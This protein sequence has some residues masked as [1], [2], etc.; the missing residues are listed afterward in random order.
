[1]ILIAD[2]GS[3]KTEWRGIYNGSS[4]T[5][6]TKGINP[7]HQTSEEIF[8]SLKDDFTIDQTTIKEIYFYGAGCANE[9]KINIVRKALRDFFNINNITV[10]SD[11]TGAARSLCGSKPGIACILGTG[12]NSCL[13]DG[14]NIKDNVSP[15]GYI[16][17]DE[18]SGA[19]MGKKLIGDILKNQL[20]E[21]VIRLFFREHNTNRAQILDNIYKK[22]LANRYLAQ[23]TKFLSKHIEIEEIYNLV[24]NAFDEFIKR[25]LLQYNN[26]LHLEINF[27]GSIAY[28]FQEQ[29]IKALNKN[30]LT[31][32]AVTQSPMDGLEQYHSKTK[33]CLVAKANKTKPSVTESSSKFDNLEIMSVEKL[34]TS[35]NH[36]DAYVH[37]AVAK[38][39]PQVKEL[40]ERIV[41]RMQKG[42]RVFYLGAG[43][44]GRL[45]V[46][47]ASELPPTF[48]VPD[49]MVIGL[50]AGGDAAL[51]KAVEAAEDDPDKAWKELLAFDIN[52]MDTVIGIAASG[53][54]PYVVGGIRQARY[55]GLLTGCITCNPNSKVAQVTEY[56]IEAIVGPEFVTGSTRLKAGTAQKMILNMMTTTIMIK[57]GRVKGNQMVNMQLTSEKLVDRGSR[58]I[59][60]ETK[61]AYED[62]KRLLL[63]H[64]SVKK[65]IEAYRNI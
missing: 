20:P 17:G 1:M 49:N 23:F 60:E 24:T 54:T 53:S 35:I 61:L 12:S 4:Q 40:V 45:G 41:D 48:G 29:L 55:N 63:L 50:I 22:P 65:A 51:R 56:P 11:L 3:T 37:V 52:E 57:L 62:A 44:S 38:A 14:R 32:G 34:I 21:Q 6:I 9:D 5:C 43:T 59:M 8:R 39:L 7:F 19:V 64:G 30:H 46:L 31:L 58:M 26:V 18:G 42:G 10:E 36:E 33:N 25:N 2:S 28:H 13:Y 15:L 16:I 47:D 27:T